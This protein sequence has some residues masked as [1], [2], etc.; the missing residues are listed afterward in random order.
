MKFIWR[1]IYQILYI[2]FLPY[3]ANKDKKQFAKVMSFSD[4]LFA[5]LGKNNKFN[6]N[7]RIKDLQDKI[8]WIHGVSLGEINTAILLIN[9][10]LEK[11]PHHKILI[12]TH[13]I[14]GFSAATSF[15]NKKEVNGKV[16]VALL[17]FDLPFALN[18][19]INTYQ[20]YTLILIESDLWPAVSWICKRHHLPFFI[21]NARVSP[22]SKK[23]INKFLKF[24]IDKLFEKPNLIIA[25][26]QEYADCWRWLTN[27]VEIG[28]QIKYDIS[29]P[30][31][32]LL[33]GEK[34]TAYLKNKTAKKILMFASTREGEEEIALNI[35]EKLSHTFHQKYNLVIIP[36]HPARVNE[37]AKIISEHK[38][39]S[40]NRSQID[41]LEYID[42]NVW[43]GDSLGEMFAYYATAD[44]VVIG[45]SLLPFGGQNPI[46]AFAIGVPVILGAHTYNFA[47][48]RED[49][50][51]KNAAVGITSLAGED[52]INDIVSLIIKLEDDI[53][54]TV[55]MKKNQKILIQNNQGAIAKTI[56][57]L[58]NYLS[59][60]LKA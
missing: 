29:V 11:Y 43:L 37:V 49:A 23:R 1:T 5:K 46:E 19:F 14:T 20:P 44:I 60:K 50:I 24:Q 32:Q 22:K 35:W 56:N 40:Q 36:R 3:I 26:N 4:W 8:I 47:K 27:K 58:N 55:Q 18:N 7:S 39:S 13:T 52:V 53:N 42:G 51:S 59:D 28:G 15:A 2:L 10:W 6:N 9:N 41:K 31:E 33:L 12:T 54:I 17:T 57:I 16:I 45:G 21:V 34:F 38:L 25:Q 48:V 30:Q